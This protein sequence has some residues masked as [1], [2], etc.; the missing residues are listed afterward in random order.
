MKNILYFITF[1]IVTFSFSQSNFSV[2]VDGLVVGDSAR[3]IMQKGVE[4]SIQK[5]VK[6]TDESST[7]QADFQ[8]GNGQWALLMDAT[9]YT[10]PSSTLIQIPE[11][12]SATYSLTPMLNDDF[13]YTW[14]DDDS[15]VGHA[16]QAYV[17][18]PSEIVIINDTISVPSDYSSIK[19]RNE[20]G[21]VLSNDEEPWSMDDSYRLYKMFE[22]LPYNTYGEGSVIDLQSGEDVRGIFTLSN[23]NI[24]QDLTITTVDGIKNGR[25]GID[26]FTYAEPQIVTIDGIKGKFYSKR[27]Y[28][29]VVNFVSNFGSE[30]GI[31]D[32][33]AQER[34]G[35][36]FMI[37]NQETEDLMGEDS[38]NFQEFF[39]WEK[40]EIL[41]MFEEL[42]EGFHKLN[43]LDYLVRRITGQDNP[44]RP[45]AAAIAWGGLGTIEWMS[46]AFNG[47]DINDVK[48]IIIHEK[49]HFIYW[50]T[51]DEQTKVDW[52]E[53]GGWF[54]DP[55]AASGWSTYMTNGFV[56]PYAHANNPGEDFAESISF[57]LTNPDALLSVSV[58]KYEFIRDR[59][60]H[61]T[62]YIAMIPDELT[63]IV[64][65]L[66]PDYVFPGK[67]T[68][69]EIDVTG[70]PEEDKQITVRATLNSN[71]VSLDG[72]AWGYLRMTSTIGTFVDIY[73]SPENGQSL[74]SV[75]VGSTI[76]NK[77]FKSGYW[78]LNYLRIGDQV[79]NMRYENT[80]T[81]GWKCWIENPL[82]D[83]QPPAWEYDYSSEVVEGYFNE[84]Y[85]PSPVAEEDGG[86]FMRAIKFLFTSYDNSPMRRALLRIWNPTLDDPDAEVYEKQI[87]GRPNGWI[88]EEPSEGN[89]FNSSKIFE[90][91]LAI[92]EWFPSGY[93]TTVMADL[94]D[95]AGNYSK[96]FFV[97]DTT[98]FHIS[99][100]DADKRFKDVRDSIYVET[101]YPDYLQSELDLNN[102]TIIAEPTN[103]ESPNGETRVDITMIARD[104]SDYPGY[105]S[106]VATVGFTLRDPQGGIHGFQTGNSTM[107]HPDLNIYDFNPALNSNWGVYNFD[108]VLPVGSPPGEWGMASAQIRDKA[109]NIKNYSFVEFVRFDIIQ[110][111]VELEVPLEAT[112]LSDYVNAANVENIS[113]TISCIPCEGLNY[114]YTI[115]SLTGGAVVQGTGV[116]ESNEITLNQIDT[117]GVLDGNIILTVQVT[118]TESQLI[119]TKSTEYIKD[120]FYPN[121][122]YSSSNIQEQGTSNLDDIV[123]AVVV[124]GQDVNGT[125]DLDIENVE[126]SN[127]ANSAISMNGNI[128]TEN[129]DITNIN[130]YSIDDGYLKTILTITDFVGNVGEPEITYYYKEDGTIYYV[131]NSII[132]TDEDG[133][134]DFR[135]NCPLIANTDQSDIDSDGIGDVCD[136]DMDGD[137]ILNTEDNCHT[138]PNT[139]QSDIDSDGIGDVCDEDM[140]GDTILNAEDNCQTTPNTDQSDIDSDGI[141][142]VCDED[143]DG[144]TILNAEDNCQTNPNTDQSDIDSDGIGDVCDE[145]LAPNDNYLIFTNSITCINANNGSINLQ[146][147]EQSIDYLLIFNNQTYELNES[148][149]HSFTTNGLSPGIYSICITIPEI[150]SYEQCFEIEITQPDSFFVDTDVDYQSNIIYFELEGA[151]QY[152]IVYNN[153]IHSTTS[154]QISFNLN[155]GENNFEIYTDLE[156]QGNIIKN[157]YLDEKIRYYPNPIKNILSLIVPQNNLFAK[158]LIFDINGKLITQKNNMTIIEGKIE[159]DLSNLKS[160]KYILNI[161]TSNLN[162]IIKIVKK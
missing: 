68:K 3:V 42:P 70:L 125:Y 103:P 139:D 128:E 30:S 129:F 53:I 138:T 137:T 115:Y 24:D 43:G 37:P 133:H 136:E 18:E 50:N 51:V 148:N 135:D 64:Y 111:D 67:V 114:V 72:A 73:L 65:N 83:I 110:S 52:R 80:S 22:A 74:D 88:G 28:N 21:I 54:E 162:K 132:D 151:E 122:Y 150:E 119:A 100:N 146:V 159:L 63:F 154:N 36:R 81:I 38:S 41:S 27:L 6:R 142:D 75:I 35:V 140:D 31:L 116:F 48:R 94:E 29:A 4:N 14:Q 124:E 39:D 99:P 106:G 131:G 130:F 58:E 144:D 10:Y 57:Y 84:D 5:W 20:Y 107:N 160:G 153:Q 149:G 9:G 85:N 141:G 118:D 16:T 143:M 90:M 113:A 32:W 40:V 86:V 1:L 112:I 61:G 76:M 93:Y 78:N 82:E 7:V 46:K 23:D 161:E 69:I 45:D 66:F 71:D 13:T 121:S 109:G 101:S 156:C 59:V 152:Y 123:I 155:D 147:N 26:A 15:Y 158:I 89:E 92:P 105:E 56:S 87:Q 91:Y 25:V 95:V 102:I 47:E 157:I 127:F 96:V 104:L 34:F 79:G 55:T 117:S 145:D 126:S 108:L 60:M 44:T 98:D 17:N 49:A 12:T 97:N 77:Y 33:I 2:Y 19:L 8:V 134:G 11:Q 62:R 120:T